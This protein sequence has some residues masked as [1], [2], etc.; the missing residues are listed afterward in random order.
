GR[1]IHRVHGGPGR[2]VAGC[3]EIDDREEIVRAGI[4]PG[5]RAKPVQP[6]ERRDHRAVVHLVVD[7]G[8]PPCVGGYGDGGHTW[9]ESVE[10]ESH[11]ARFVLGGRGSGGRGWDVIVRPSVLVER[12]Q[13][14]RVDGVGTPGR[15]RVLD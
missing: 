2:G 1:N 11:L 13:Q 7:D 9:T 14:Q 4:A 8:V 6:R 15:R 5:Q 3:L 12:D 10:R